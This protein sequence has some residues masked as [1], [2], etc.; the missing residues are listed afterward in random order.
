MGGRGSS[1]KVKL[2]AL[3]LTGSEKQKAWGREIRS[4]YAGWVKEYG[5][6]L[7]KGTFELTIPRDAPASVWKPLQEQKANANGLEAT[8]KKLV[9]ASFG[10]ET[11]KSIMLYNP[12]NK[13]S[14]KER[15]KDLLEAAKRALKKETSAKFWIDN[16]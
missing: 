13:K 12:K 4:R 15:R 3:D 6:E 14:M 8:M 11:I 2:D 1:S 7:K 16:R 10:E 9:T 5:D